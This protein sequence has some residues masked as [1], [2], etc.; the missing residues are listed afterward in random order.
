MRAGRDLVNPEASPFKAGHAWEC[1]RASVIGF[2][3]DRYSVSLTSQPE[4]WRC[5]SLPLDSAR[6][7]TNALS[8]PHQCGSTR[9]IYQALRTRGGWLPFLFSGLTLFAS[10]YAAGSTNMG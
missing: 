3:D 10:D 1:V 8:F 9:L 5:Y 2:R 7:H 6:M 4:A